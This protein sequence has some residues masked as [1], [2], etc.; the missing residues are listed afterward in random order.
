[1]STPVIPIRRTRAPR[2]N[3]LLRVALLGSLALAAAGVAVWL[4]ASGSSSGAVE[5]QGPSAAAIGAFEEKTGVQLVRV[6]LTGGSGIIDLRYRVIDPDK[7]LV[8]HD[9]DKRPAIVD[10]ATG[11]VI[12]DPFMGMW[13]HSKSIKPGVVYYQLFVNRQ[14]LIEPGGRVSVRLGGVVLRDVLVE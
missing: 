6:A 7:G 9:P 8:V 11:G 10:E 13:M 1:M 12:G 3:I 5:R 14:R 2:A 4:L